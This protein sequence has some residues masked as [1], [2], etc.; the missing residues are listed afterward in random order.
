[1]TAEATE[2]RTNAH[3][4]LNASQDSPVQTPLQKKTIYAS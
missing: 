1:M 2:S 3:K 4:S